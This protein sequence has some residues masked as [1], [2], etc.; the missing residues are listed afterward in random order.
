M[1]TH[2]QPG[3]GHYDHLFGLLIILRSPAPHQSGW[4]TPVPH[5]CQS[6]FQTHCHQWSAKIITALPVDREGTAMNYAL[7]RHPE[8]GLV[9]FHRDIDIAGDNINSFAM[10]RL[11]ARRAS[12][13]VPRSAQWCW[14]CSPVPP[15]RIRC[16]LYQRGVVPQPKKDCAVGNGSV[17][18]G[19][20]SVVAIVGEWGQGLGA[21][22]RR[23]L[24]GSDGLHNLLD[25]GC[26]SVREINWLPPTGRHDDRRR[27]GAAVSCALMR[28][29]TK[30]RSWN[31]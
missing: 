12:S 6:H 24:G 13:C 31:C 17:D 14:S 27:P 25:G 29:T 3:I 30:T 2:L 26:A 5:R 28:W 15:P 8:S 22:A 16:I 9:Q 7:S 1:L 4:V 18:G 20:T 19:S 21:A 11:C 23:M 10:Q